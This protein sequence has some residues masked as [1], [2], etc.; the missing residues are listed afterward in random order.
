MTG[1]DADLG[2]PPWE[3]PETYREQVAAMPGSADWLP[4]LRDIAA[5]YAERWGLSPDGPAMHGW[6]SPAWPVVDSHQHKAV[7][8]ITPPVSWIDGE[9]AALEAWSKQ[10]HRDGEPRMII[11]AA[12]APEDRVVL[13]PR[14]DPTRSLEDHPDVDEAVEIIGRILASIAGT[15]PVPGPGTLAAEL[16]QIADGLAD[17][18]PV[19]ADQLD[20]A[21]RAIAELRDHL[22]TTRQTLLHND[23][24][25]ANVLHARPGD[26]PAWFGIDP[27]PLI[28]IG[29]WEAIP[30]LRNRWP[31]AAASGDPDRSLRRRVDQ[32]CEIT[33]YDAELVRRCAQ[34]VAVSNLHWILPDRRDHLHA[35]AYLIMA[36]W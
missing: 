17:D 5:R 2:R 30:L 15:P 6:I 29:E 1:S 13:L 19:P 12:V 26:K 18:G 36:G 32:L 4:T 31:A 28:G 25:F 27:F 21:R 11:P 8:K 10:D 22:G 20:R 14:L 34:I 9:A 35:S 23:L 24:H 3:L 7:L 33:G 16:D